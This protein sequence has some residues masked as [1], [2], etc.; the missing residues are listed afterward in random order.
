[1][2]VSDIEENGDYDIKVGLS[3]SYY[4]SQTGA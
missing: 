1:M 2:N 4:L 3:D